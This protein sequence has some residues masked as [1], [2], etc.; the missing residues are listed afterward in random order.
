VKIYNGGKSEHSVKPV[1][2]LQA[3]GSK[4][5]NAFND[6]GIK[7][8]EKP[9]GWNAFE[10]GAY[11]AKYAYT[12]LQLR[13]AEKALGHRLKVYTSK[14]IFGTSG[15]PRGML[16]NADFP[17]EEMFIVDFGNNDRWIA[18]TT[19]ANTYIRNWAKLK[20]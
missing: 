10:D 16:A 19:G 18:D 13:R 1:T 14:E 6:A 20:T 7:L 15:R 5:I 9:D 8:A 12:E 3:F 17:A 4:E 2:M 11:L